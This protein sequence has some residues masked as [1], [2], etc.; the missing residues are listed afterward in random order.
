MCSF[1]LCAKTGLATCT[2]RGSAGTRPAVHATEELG[3]RNTTG[4]TAREVAPA[5]E[6]QEQQY[7]QQQE[8]TVEEHFKPR[9]NHSADHVQAR[10]TTAGVLPVQPYTCRYG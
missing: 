3:T 8:K 6:Q 10:T 7:M 1:A 5:C 9:K 4:E 2:R